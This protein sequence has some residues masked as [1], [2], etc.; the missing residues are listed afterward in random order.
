[1][2]EEDF[3]RGPFHLGRWSKPIAVVAFC[4]AVFACIMFILPPVLPVTLEVRRASAAQNCEA[5][6][7][8]VLLEAGMHCTMKDAELRVW[9]H[10]LNAHATWPMTYQ[11]TCESCVCSTLQSQCGHHS[12]ASRV[13]VLSCQ[14][15]HFRTCHNTSLWFAASFSNPFVAV[16]QPLCH[17]WMCRTCVLTLLVPHIHTHTHTHHQPCPGINLLVSCVSQCCRV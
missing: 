1:M 17:S 3:V 4:W 14:G 13:F 6:M 9:M 8:K 2:R 16:Q 10:M 12:T 5:T 7:M 15:H 11:R